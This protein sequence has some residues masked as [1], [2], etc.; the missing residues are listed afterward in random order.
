MLL[1]NEILGHFSRNPIKKPTGFTQIS[2]KFVK[3][4]VGQPFLVHFTRNT[5]KTNAKLSP[6]MHSGSGIIRSGPPDGPRRAQ[7][8]RRAGLAG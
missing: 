6:G 8:A 1:K 7:P 5:I 4:E 3:K 2:L